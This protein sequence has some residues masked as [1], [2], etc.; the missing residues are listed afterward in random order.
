[1][2]HWSQA[3]LI[4]C[5]HVSCIM[6]GSPSSVGFQI[7]CRQLLY[8]APCTA[9]PAPLASLGR[10]GSGPPSPP[11]SFRL[12]LAP[13]APPRGAGSAAAAPGENTLPA[14]QHG[15]LVCDGGGCLS[16]RRRPAYSVPKHM[17]LRWR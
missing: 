6:P 12:L 17:Q 9:H 10:F 16:A 2:A 4:G 5:S 14:R 13:P 11:P 1:M 3:V 15:S 8:H 7:K